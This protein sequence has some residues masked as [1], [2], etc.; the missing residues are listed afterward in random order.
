MNHFSVQYAIN[1]GIAEAVKKKKLVN[2]NNKLYFYLKKQSSKKAI[3]NNA[4][5]LNVQMRVL[6]SVEHCAK[7]KI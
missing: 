2:D 3:I 5:W 4:P 1:F 6:F 7:R